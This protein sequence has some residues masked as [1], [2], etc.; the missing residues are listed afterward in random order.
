MVQ[1]HFEGEAWGLALAGDDKIITCCDDNRV[2]M[3]D[4]RSKQFVRGGKVSENQMNVLKKS[5]AASS[6]K[7][8]PNK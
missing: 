2:M 7:M 1:S 6:S 8:P 4:A 5:T 3:F